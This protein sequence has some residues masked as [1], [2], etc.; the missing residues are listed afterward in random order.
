MTTTGS[1]QRDVQPTVRAR[2][3]VPRTLAMLGL[4]ATAAAG[5]TWAE[6]HFAGR[7]HLDRQTSA[8][9]ASQDSAGVRNALVGG[10]GQ[11]QVDDILPGSVTFPVTVTSPEGYLGRRYAL[12]AKTADCGLVF[13][14]TAPVTVTQGCAGYL[15]AD[16]VRQDDQAVYSSVTVL[17][18]PDPAAASLVAK[19][20]KRPGAAVADLLFRQ[21]GA[22]LPATAAQPV[23]TPAGGLASAAAGILP[24]LQPGHGPGLGTGTT[25]SPSGT[26]TP[27]PTTTAAPPPVSHDPANAATRVQIA[28]VGRVVTVVQSAFAD[29]RPASPDLDT[30][31]WYLSYTV[32]AA[33]AWEPDQPPASAA[34]TP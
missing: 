24:N 34:P 10:A 1:Q 23:G 30:P 3:R 16:Y 9:G 7:I 2:R 26:G 29:G 4:L 17:Y 33:L 14:A 6:V 5:G 19:T 20:L 22:G 31:T 32:A 11:T 8:D 27:T 12:D 13:A 25:A 21:P 18:Y 15:T 28:A